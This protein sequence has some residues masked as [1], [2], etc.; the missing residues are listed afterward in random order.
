MT[1][2]E[3]RRDAVGAFASMVLLGLEQASEPGLEYYGLTNW[4]RALRYAMQL[5][6]NTQSTIFKCLDVKER[7]DKEK[8][9][10]NER[11]KKNIKGN[12]WN[13]TKH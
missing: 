8:E 6:V 1:E 12:G 3:A 5:V 4:D 2:V 10:L 7:R 9:G 13:V 11:E